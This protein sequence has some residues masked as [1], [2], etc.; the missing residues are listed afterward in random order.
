MKKYLFVFAAIFALCP[1][2]S[3]A[4][5]ERKFFGFQFA[6]G[7]GYTF[8]GDSDLNSNMNKMMDRG[9]ARLILYTDAGMTFKLTEELYIL[10]GVQFM[11]DS[12]WNGGSYSNHV[13]PT[14]FGG[15]QFYPGIANLSFS[16]SY[17]LGFRRDWDVLDYN[18]GNYKN[19][20]ASKWGNGFRLSAEYDFKKGGGMVPAIGACYL[21]MPT[22]W[23][24]YDN[25]LALYFRL[26]FR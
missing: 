6:L 8:Y 23:D 11:G 15:V 2:F 12:A 3:F 17:A 1:L 21:F 4:E 19:A 13:A 18:Y 5:S 22:G 16:L 10:S 20:R 25:T 26:A 7:S 14:F 24:N 9:Y